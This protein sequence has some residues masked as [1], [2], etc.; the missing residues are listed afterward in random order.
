MNRFKIRIKFKDNI[1]Y[2]VE[3]LELDGY[4]STDCKLTLG[5]RCQD[6]ILSNYMLH[7]AIFLPAYV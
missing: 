2:F 6:G 3:S 7:G 5:K 1:T 4:S